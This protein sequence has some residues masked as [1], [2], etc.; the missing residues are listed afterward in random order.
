MI[1][2]GAIVNISKSLLLFEETKNQ[3]PNKKE[4]IIFLNGMRNHWS[5]G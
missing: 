1:A 3:Y 2:R 4:A 5:T